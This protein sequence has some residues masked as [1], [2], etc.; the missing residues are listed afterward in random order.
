MMGADAMETKLVEKALSVGEIRLS[1]LFDQAPVGMALLDSVTGRFQDMNAKY[2][3]ITGYSQEEMRALTFMDITHPDDLRSDLDHMAGPLRGQG[4][5]F[6]TDQRYC[7]KDGVTVWVRL[8]CIPVR[9]DATESRLHVA[10]VEDITL[11]KQAEADLYESE[12]K[13]RT[14]A[15]VSPVPMVMKDE[16]RRLVYLNPAFIRVFGYDLADVPALAVWW[17]RACPDPGYRAWVEETWRTRL[18][19][20]MRERRL[21]DPFEVNVLCKDGTK[22]TVMVGASPLGG[23][24]KELRLVTLQDITYRKQAEGRLQALA[25]QLAMAEEQERRRVVRELHDEF[26]QS[27]TS[28]KMDLAWMVRQLLMLPDQPKMPVMLNKIQVMTELTDGLIQGI[29]RLCTELRPSILDDL[30]LVAALRVLVRPFALHR[31]EGRQQHC[32]LSCSPD[33]E[34][35]S[36]DSAVATAFYRIAQEGLTNVRRH[37][38]ASEVSVELARD[39]DSLVLHVRDNGRG[40]TDADRGKANANGL[41]GMRERARQLGGSCT[42]HS[43]L[44]QGTTVCARIKFTQSN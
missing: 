17:Q 37:A 44:G 2:C 23:A 41:L 16:G 5:S 13:W 43:M 9:R 29:R 24:C 39:G 22:R 11:R 27:L 38:E 33:V 25:R 6:Q 32:T 30:G 34:G 26:G 3:E 12:I 28:L 8:T 36:I 7:R 31:L 4:G 19:E 40:L 1:A 14:I 18:E 10:I 21:F 20:A 42:I 15:N 35:L